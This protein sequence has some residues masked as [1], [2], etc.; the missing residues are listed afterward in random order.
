MV[1]SFPPPSADRNWHIVSR[2]HEF[3]GEARANLLR[4]AAIGCF[5]AVELLDYHGLR[6]GS[7]E[8]PAIVNRPF[9]QM[10]TGLALAWALMGLV[11]LLL[12]KNRIFPAAL[13]YG[14]TAG[15]L[16]FLTA[17]LVVASGPQS[18][19]VIGY[20]LII[21]LATLRFSL[22]LVRFASAGAVAGYLFV[23]GHGKWFA[24]PPRGVPRHQQ[25]IVM[26][27][28]AL[29][30]VILGQIVRRGARMAQEYADRVAAEKEDAP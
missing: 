22:G 21:V 8:I 7:F 20:F 28:L 5:Y 11:V 18:P 27:G 24:N 6:I 3:E 30:G 2:W 13:K 4:I 1:S 26:I 9:H 25:L 14:T 19:L 16:V 12:Q 10:M 15:D 17:V 29:T 23:L